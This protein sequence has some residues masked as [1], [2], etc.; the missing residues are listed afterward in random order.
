MK[1][2]GKIDNK[3]NYDECLWWGEHIAFKNWGRNAILHFW[4]PMKKKEAQLVTW[5]MVFIKIESVA[6]FKCSKLV[7]RRKIS[8][9][10]AKNDTACIEENKEDIRFLIRHKVKWE[11]NSGNLQKYSRKKI[12]PRILYSE[13]VSFKNKGEIK[14]FSD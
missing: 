2:L 10:P 13:K 11:K 12:Q 14:N 8:N 9:Q 3:E 7:I 6:E 5:F 4:Q 1:I